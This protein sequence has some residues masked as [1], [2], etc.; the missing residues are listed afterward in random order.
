MH[1]YKVGQFYL[2]I[3]FF[4]VDY[5]T[6]IKEQAASIAK[7]KAYV[8]E[9]ETDNASKDKIIKE[10]EDRLTNKTQTIQVQRYRDDLEIAHIIP[11]LRLCLQVFENNLQ[12][13]LFESRTTMTKDEFLASLIEKLHI[14]K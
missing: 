12:E 8:K 11:R 6:I 9:L 10:K 2:N 1:R 4:K 5:Q 7:L 3:S 14:E 13:Y